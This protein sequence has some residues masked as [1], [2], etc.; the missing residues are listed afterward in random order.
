MPPIPPIS[1]SHVLRM[2]PR[3]SRNPV[4]GHPW[5]RARFHRPCDET[6]PCDPG[7]ASVPLSGR[8]QLVCMMTCRG[9]NTVS[10]PEEAGPGTGTGRD[11]RP[12]RAEGH[13]GWTRLR[14]T[15]PRRRGRHYERPRKRSRRPNRRTPVRGRGAHQK[16]CTPGRFHSLPPCHGFPPRTS[17]NRR[18]AYRAATPS[19]LGSTPIHGGFRLAL[20]H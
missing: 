1:R 19:S 14:R 15:L 20:L 3:G 17:G 2:C 6:G 8:T 16:K 4:V 9:P 18:W 7:M 12:N 11:D 5:S 10:F 13:G